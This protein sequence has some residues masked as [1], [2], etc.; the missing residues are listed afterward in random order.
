MSLKNMLLDLVRSNEFT[1][2]QAILHLDSIKDVSV[3]H[4]E[5]KLLELGEYEEIKQAILDLVI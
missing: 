5:Y 3:K 2:E 1:K 4:P